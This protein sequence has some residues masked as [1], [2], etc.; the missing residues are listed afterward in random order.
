MGCSPNDSECNDDE[1]P[2]RRVR[3]TRGF[4]LGQT[5]VTQAA[6][7]KLIGTNPSYFKAP[8][9][10]VD[11]VNWNEARS[12]CEAFGGRLPSEAEWE[13]AARAGTAGPRYG[14]L[15]A[16]AW[17]AD[18]S[19]NRGLNSIR[20]YEKDAHKDATKYVEIL[21][22][23]G[24]R[25]HQVKQKQP[26]SW[27]LY[28]MLGNVWEWVSDWFEED[29]RKLPW[30]AIDPKGPDSGTERVLRGGCW[31]L[32]PYNAR[33]SSRFHSVP[34]DNVFYSGFRCVREVIP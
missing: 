19:G 7:L 30:P 13:Y 15:D 4:W 10:P 33:A 23:N 14:Q 9:N 26:N 18:N 24:N 31:G 21:Q 27:G 1:K 6:Y 29:Y 11:S 2:S 28:D 16:V 32:Y 3:I 12:Y 8:E 22:K 20:T 5:E 17:Y 34:T 25:P